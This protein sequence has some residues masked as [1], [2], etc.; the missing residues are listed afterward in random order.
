MGDKMITFGKP[1]QHGPCGPTF[2]GLIG[3]GFVRYSDDDNAYTI[4]GYPKVVQLRR[5]TCSSRV[6]ID[7]KSS[8]T[9]DE[10]TSHEN[11]NDT[12]VPIQAPTPRLELLTKTQRN[13]IK[14]LETLNKMAS[15]FTNR[16]KD[17][18]II[19]EIN[20]VANFT[21]TQSFCVLHS[22]AMQTFVLDLSKLDTL[23]EVSWQTPIAQF[24]RAPPDTSFYTLTIGIDELILF[25]GREIDSPSIHQKS[26]FD[27]RVSNRLFIFKPANLPIISSPNSL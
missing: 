11:S 22:K 7:Y 25:G 15:K 19:N 18:K 20:N 17:D 26:T 10:V 1:R 24:A 23:G 3:D 12:T 6:I 8:L 2:N 21:K 9:D 14:R 5:C 4:A 16:Q 13:N 27:H